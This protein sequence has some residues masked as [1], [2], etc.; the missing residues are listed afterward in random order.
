MHKPRIYIDTSVIGGCFDEEFSEWSNKLFDELVSGRFIVLVSDLTLAELN[1]SDKKIVDK[2]LHI[3]IDFL[4]YV[5]RNEESEFLANKYIEHKAISNKYFED[6]HHIALATIY[7][8]DL[9]VSWNFKHIVN[10]SR[11]SVYNSVNTLLN[12]S[13]I[14]IR[15]PREVVQ[16]EE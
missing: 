5:H 4:E 14:N 1:R 11:I 6:A 12:Y 15:S 16:Y 10:I 13:M 9:L 7:Y 3:P 8:S 2:L